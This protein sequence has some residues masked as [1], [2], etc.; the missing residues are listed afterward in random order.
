MNKKRM[1]TTLVLVLVVAAG[2]R[3]ADQDVTKMPGYVDLDV[4]KV[5]DDATEVRLVDLGPDMLADVAKQETEHDELARIISRIQA[6]HVKS[7]A[8]V[9]EQ[10]DKI[11]GYVN[12]LD[13]SL[14]KGGWKRLIF[15]QG[16]EE[17]VSVSTLRHAEGIGGW[18]V[19][20]IDDTDATFANL[21]GDIDLAAI[22]SLAMGSDKGDLDELMAK[23]QEQ[24]GA[25]ADTH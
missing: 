8:F 3:A 21:V 12:Q 1:A 23:L 2:A 11:Q 7:F 18:M 20:V 10:R 19:M 6:I 5:P 4:V 13:K 25:A 24:A 14:T 9:P 17:L 16:K 15:V 22:A